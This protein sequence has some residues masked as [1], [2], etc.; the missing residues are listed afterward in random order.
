MKNH[1]LLFT[2]VTLCVLTALMIS[3][4]FI[5]SLF[6]AESSS[7]QSTGILEFVNSLLCSLNIKFEFTEHIIRKCAHFAEFFVLAT[8]LF[9]TIKSFLSKVS[10]NVWLTLSSGLV[11]A[12]IDE[13]LQLFS[14]GRSSQFTDVLLDFSGVATAT[15]LFTLL[16]LLIK[17]RLRNKGNK[18]E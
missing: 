11:V 9:Y 15:A 10:L 16:T 12:L 17:K 13:T 1:K 14:T 5:N 6:D 2:R 7:A 8:L 18:N 3:F 4:I